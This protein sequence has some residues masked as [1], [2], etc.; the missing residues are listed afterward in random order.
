[1]E[2]WIFY[3]VTDNCKT[4][5]SLKKIDL[6]KLLRIQHTIYNRNKNLSFAKSFYSMAN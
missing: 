3:K 4:M 1:M 6:K 5:N 2:N